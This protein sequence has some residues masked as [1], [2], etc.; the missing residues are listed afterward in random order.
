MEHNLPLGIAPNDLEDYRAYR[1]AAYRGT[2]LAR[3]Q[4]YLERHPESL[5]RGK[6]GEAEAHPVDGAA[7]QSAALPF[8]SGQTAGL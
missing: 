7:F 6:P 1:V 2:R 8:G 4:A 3:A 5:I